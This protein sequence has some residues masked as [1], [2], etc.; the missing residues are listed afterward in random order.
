MRSYS[1][2]KIQ[3]DEKNISGTVSVSSCVLRHSSVDTGSRTLGTVGTPRHIMS[4]IYDQRDTTEFTSEEL[5]IYVF[6]IDGWSKRK[7]RAHYSCAVPARCQAP[8]Q[9]S[10]VMRWRQSGSNFSVHLGFPSRRAEPRRDWWRL[11]GRNL[12]SGLGVAV[13]GCGHQGITIRHSEDR[14]PVLLGTL[15]HHIVTMQAAALLLATLAVILQ[16]M[17]TAH[18]QPVRDVSQQHWFITMSF[19]SIV[20]LQTQSNFKAIS[21][22][23]KCNKGNRILNLLSTVCV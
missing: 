9:I 8:A 2:Q 18:S 5:I 10:E 11:A 19:A 21:I 4:G 22:F 23:P 7:Q 20:I 15:L 14:G 1:G 17:Q 16:T 6:P 13:C 12:C 3:F